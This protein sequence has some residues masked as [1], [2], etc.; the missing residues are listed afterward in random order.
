MHSHVHENQSSKALLTVFLLNLS[1]T[2]MELWGGY[3]TGSVAILS[4]AVHDLG[5]SLAIG[6]AYYLSRLAMRAADAR[7]SYG[8]GR[9]NVL[10]AMVNSVVLLAGSLFVLKEAVDRLYHPLPTNAKGMVA[11]AVLGIAVNGFAA[12]KLRSADSVNAKV[13]SLHLMED[14]L[15]WVAVLVGA[16]VMLVADVPWLDPI[17]SI[18]I[19]AYILFG[20]LKRL[21]QT[22]LML[23]QRVPDGVDLQELE[24]RLAA[25]PGV[26]SLHETHTWTL[27]GE[28]HVFSTHLVVSPQISLDE[29][30]FIKQASRKVLHGYPFASHT[31]EVEFSGLEDHDLLGRAARDLET[32]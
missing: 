21:R 18:S 7:Y 17:L 5:D 26:Q 29:I 1:F 14:V 28:T 9:Y 22:F 8:Y 23:L 10:G 12:Y 30:K 3:W 25:I 13:V 16:A 4:D 19:S 2:L 27:D 31:V 32:D 20:V 24:T 15:G 6:S 11:F